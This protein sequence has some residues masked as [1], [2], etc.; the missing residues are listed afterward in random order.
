MEKLQEIGAYMRQKRE[1]R[2]LSRVQA[3]AFLGTSE[4]AIYRVEEGRVNTKSTLLLRYA[5]LVG[6]SG[7]YLV[8]LFAQ[9]EEVAA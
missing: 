3:A 1:E 8:G 2:G 4:Q 6:A 9:S 7:D 5:A